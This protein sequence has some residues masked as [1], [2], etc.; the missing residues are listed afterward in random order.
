MS[1]FSI[2][3]LADRN[4]NPSGH[5]KSRIGCVLPVSRW[6]HYNPK[7]SKLQ[8]FRDSWFVARDSWFPQAFLPLWGGIELLGGQSLP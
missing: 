2:I 6:R 7:I 5:R 8:V 3:I 4:Q 1:F